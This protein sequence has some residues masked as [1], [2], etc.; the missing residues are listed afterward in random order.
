[1]IDLKEFDE[2]CELLRALL[3]DEMLVQ[4]WWSS[5]NGAFNGDTPWETYRTD[6]QRVV[7]YVNWQAYR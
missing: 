5:P 3:G 6:K 4:R 7:N 1:M 2:C